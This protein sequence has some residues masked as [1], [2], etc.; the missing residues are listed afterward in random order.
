MVRWTWFPHPKISVFDKILDFCSIFPTWWLYLL[1]EVPH[2]GLLLP[3]GGAE[4]L[5]VQHLQKYTDFTHQ[6]LHCCTDIREEGV[7]GQGSM[8]LVSA[9]EGIGHPYTSKQRLRW[10]LENGFLL[11]SGFVIPTCSVT[12]HH[13]LSV[14]IS[15]LRTPP[16]LSVT[17]QTKHEQKPGETGNVVIGH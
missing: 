2:R 11:Y 1:Q 13:S 5:L 12:L 9:Q 8:A 6:Q 4:G 15:N 16:P 10:L 3:H 17:D 14:T 7:R